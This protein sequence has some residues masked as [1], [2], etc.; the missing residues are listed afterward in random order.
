MLRKLLFP[1]FFL[2]VGILPATNVVQGA[3]VNLA[4]G[5]NTYQSSTYSNDPIYDSSKGV[6]GSKSDSSMFHT[7][8]D[9]QPWWEVD[10]GRTASLQRIAHLEQRR[11]FV[12]ERVQQAENQHHR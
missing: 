7:G 4:F 5:K 9:P 3:P 6:D 8:Q 2:A 11:L 10:L 1:C 12:I